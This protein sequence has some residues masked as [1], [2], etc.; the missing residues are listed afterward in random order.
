MGCEL[1]PRSKLRF[2]RSGGLDTATLKHSQ[3]ES[4]VYVVEEWDIH[5]IMIEIDLSALSVCVPVQG[6][7]YIG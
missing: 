6:A 1:Y 3:A 2:L 5:F 4:G 7:I